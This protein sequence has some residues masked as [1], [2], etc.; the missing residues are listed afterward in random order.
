MHFHNI[1]K[2]PC[3]FSWARDILLDTLLSH[4]TKSCGHF[5]PQ[6]LER[7]MQRE[8]HFHRLVGQS[9]PMVQCTNAFSSQSKRH[10]GFTVTSPQAKWEKSTP[11]WIHFQFYHWQD[12]FHCYHFLSWDLKLFVLARS[13]SSFSQ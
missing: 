4:I 1:S 11:T 12:I 10:L 6:G 13:L 7:R 5:S 8:L 2:S 9:F 3:D